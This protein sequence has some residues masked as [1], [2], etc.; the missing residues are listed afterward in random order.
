M[1]PWAL[2]SSPATSRELNPP[3]P[4][5]EPVSLR[6]AQI[7]GTI[8]A[9]NTKGLATRVTQRSAWQNFRMPP[10][11]FLSSSPP[12]FPPL[13]T[14]SLCLSSYLNRAKDTRCI[15]QSTCFSTPN[16]ESISSRIPVRESME[17]D[18]IK[19]GTR[20]RR[21]KEQA[22]ENADAMGEGDKEREREIARGRARSLA[23]AWRCFPMTR[24][25]YGNT[26]T[27]T[28]DAMS[29]LSRVHRT[30]RIATA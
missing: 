22:E 10:P 9:A 15:L 16:G 18:E 27:R 5:E 2:E 11:L 25:A 7:I 20:K 24:T 17:Q 21:E 13:P 12:P 26:P 6:S 8:H 3:S 4:S 1:C 30:G 28:R 14:R 23:Q 29:R 19:K